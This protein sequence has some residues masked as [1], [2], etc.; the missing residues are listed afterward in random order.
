MKPIR[1]SH[2][3][4][5]TMA[6]LLLL[7]SMLDAL[8]PDVQM[9][10][11]RG[12]MLVRPVAVKVAFALVCGTEL[13]LPVS[14]PVGDSVD[15]GFPLRWS[16]TAAAMLFAI[17]LALHA[18]V[19]SG[20]PAAYT[21]LG[22]NS[23]YF[24]LLIVPALLW[25]GLRINEDTVIHSVTW[26][27]L[28]LLFIGVAQ[29][30]T[31]NPLL[32]VASSD[33]SFQIHSWK[34]YGHVRAFSLCASPSAYGTV[35]VFA[36]LLLLTAVRNVSGRRRAL[37]YVLIVAAVAGV[38]LT[39]TRAV[40]LHGALSVLVLQLLPWLR[41]RRTMLFSVPLLL[42]TLLVAGLAIYQGA[43]AGTVFSGESLLQRADTWWYAVQRWT[44][45][46]PGT[47]LFGTGFFQHGSLNIA[48]DLK[49]DSTWFAAGLQTGGTGLLLLLFLQTVLWLS[50]VG[51]MHERGRDTATAAVSFWAPWMV[52]WTLGIATTPFALVFL[53]AALT[54]RSDEETNGARDAIIVATPR[55]TVVWTL[56]AAI[57][58]AMLVFGTL[59]SP[60]ALDGTARWESRVRMKMLRHAEHEY[61][62]ARGRWCDGIDS[63]LAFSHSARVVYGSGDQFIPLYGSS[64][65]ADSLRCAPRSGRPYIVVASPDGAH[66]QIRDPDG[67][68]YI[69]S[70]TV[71]AEFDTPSWE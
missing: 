18:F 26:L 50:L 69:S 48:G 16:I 66:Y 36:V 20:F 68:G 51:M 54:G 71:E 43:G 41:R 53:L 27:L 15:A 19:L 31:G 2:H 64:I 42:G 8:L 44:G 35:L 6:A 55:E 29:V 57:F 3:T 38:L 21:L 70:W 28:P 25:S 45:D 56:G 59:S 47:L 13:L 58:A 9:L 1:R 52:L 32:P 39:R 49:I 12:T 34:F 67:F 40:W 5:A 37:F 33:G 62:A 22:F 7:L 60:S 30:F 46:G 63:L 65:S 61:R 11:L 14:K 4:L 23:F 24:F 10:L 17:F